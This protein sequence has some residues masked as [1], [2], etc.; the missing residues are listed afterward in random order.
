MLKGDF[1][2]ISNIVLIYPGS[3]EDP[4]YRNLQ[5]FYLRLISLIPRDINVNLIVR[6]EVDLS[7]IEQSRNGGKLRIIQTKVFRDI[8]ARD[9][10][11]FHDGHCIYKPTFK[12]SG[13]DDPVWFDT[14]YK[15]SFNQL[16]EDFLQESFPSFKLTKIDLNWDGGNLTHNGKI[17]FITDKIL[18]DNSHLSKDGILSIIKDELHIQPILI[19]S[20]QEDLLCHTDGYM[21]FISEHLST[22]PRYPRFDFTESCRSYSEYL[23]SVMIDNHIPYEYIFERPVET[24]ENDEFASAEGNYVNYLHLNDTVI[25]PKFRKRRTA[26]DLDFASV[27]RAM[28]SDHFNQILEIDCM[29]IAQLGGLLRCISWTY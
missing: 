10:F 2:K 11:G 19:D 13:K 17:G 12:P 21:S 25:I 7:Q 26:Q 4:Y 1:D 24:Y 23:R 29:Q 6:P 3:F 8:W 18:L 28:L 15:Y 27:N 5:S 14:K 16:V 20:P 9:Y 22:I